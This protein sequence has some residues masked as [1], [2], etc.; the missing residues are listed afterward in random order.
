[1]RRCCCAWKYRCPTTSVCDPPPKRLRRAPQGGAAGGP[2]KPVPQRP[3]AA[4]SARNGHR[5]IRRS[6]GHRRGQAE[7]LALQG[8]RAGLQ[9]ARHH[10]VCAGR[11]HGHDP[12][13]TER[14][15]MSTKTACRR[16]RRWAWCWATPASGPRT[17]PP[18]STGSRCCTA[19][20]PGLHAPL[21]AAGTVIGTSRVTALVDK[22]A[23]KGAL[24]YSERDIIDAASGRCWRCR[25]ACPSCAATAASPPP[26]SSPTTRRRRVRPRPTR[27]PTML[28]ADDAAGK[29]ADLPP[30]RR[31]QPGA[32]R[33]GGGPVGR[34][35]AADPA[36][37]CAASASPATRC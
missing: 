2:A 37:P 25:A 18:A 23:G 31:L 24:M 22:G 30:V 17:R 32:C 15:A 13:D 10:P 12:M 20:R 29:R 27:R 34:L 16:C 26:A 36:R 6:H 3:L 14:C 21:P 4:A 7:G 11:G 28:R 33:P 35:R 1:M 19:S 5:S 8:H 9:R